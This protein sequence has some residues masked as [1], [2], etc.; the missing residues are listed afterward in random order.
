VTGEVLLEP[1]TSAHVDEC[2]KRIGVQGDRSCP[3]L[4]AHAHCQNC[5]TY[6]AVAAQLLQGPAPESYA[7][8]WTQFYGRPPE[9]VEQATGSVLIFRVDQEWLA[10]PTTVVSEVTTPR[11]IHSLPHRRGGIV[12]GLVNVGGHLLVCAS[13]AETLGLSA[14]VGSSQ[15]AG[16]YPRFLVIRHDDVRAVCPVDDVHG[17]ETMRAKDVRPL[18]ATLVNGTTYSQG[19]LNWNGRSVGLLDPQLLLARLKRSFA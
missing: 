14:G 19:L 10:L 3:E 18:P 8:E 16:G 17:V 6:R 15:N 7:A 1:C 11:R 4:T 5:P 9:V 13:L 2:W 12:L